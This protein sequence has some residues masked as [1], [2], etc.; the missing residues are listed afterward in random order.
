MRFLAFVALGT[1]ACSPPSEKWTRVAAERAPL[2][3]EPEESGPPQGILR[4]GDLVKVLRTMKPQ[5][6]WTGPLDGEVASRTGECVEV[7]RAAGEASGFAFRA[8]LE[9]EV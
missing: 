1:F 3:A 6:A 8:D 7:E 5:L 2:L 4:Q 9:D